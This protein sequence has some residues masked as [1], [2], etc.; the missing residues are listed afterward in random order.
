MS[1]K[2]KLGA[3]VSQRVRL[4]IDSLPEDVKVLYKVRVELRAA[5]QNLLKVIQIFITRTCVPPTPTSTRS[6]VRNLNYTAI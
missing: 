5:L 2:P 6:K 3:D 1:V 4:A